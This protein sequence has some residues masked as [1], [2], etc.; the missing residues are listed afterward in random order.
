MFSETVGNIFN[1]E[2]C[3]DRLVCVNQK[4][5]REVVAKNHISNQLRDPCHAPHTLSESFLGFT[6]YLSH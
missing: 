4:L 6:T 5:F 2:T 1:N 3:K